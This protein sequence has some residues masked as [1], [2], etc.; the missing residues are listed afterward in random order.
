MTLSLWRIA[1]CLC[2]N[3]PRK[4]NGLQSIAWVYTITNKM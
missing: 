1:E 2:L 4:K 3:S